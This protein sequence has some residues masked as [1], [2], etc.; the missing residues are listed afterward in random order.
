MEIKHI[1]SH[2]FCDHIVSEGEITGLKFFYI[3]DEQT[4]GI[5]LTNIMNKYKTNT[6][7]SRILI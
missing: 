3:Y 5:D 6:L 7:Y 4:V 1:V 2:E